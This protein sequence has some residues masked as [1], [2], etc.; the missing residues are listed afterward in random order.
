MK[1]LNRKLLAPIGAAVLG[2]LGVVLFRRRVSQGTPKEKLQKI[3]GPKAVHQVDID[4]YMG[5]WFEIARYPNPSEQRCY[6]SAIEYTRRP[7]G[8]IVV[9]N[10][11]RRGSFDAPL[12]ANEGIAHVVNDGTNTRLSM[13]SFWPFTG[14]Y[15][16]VDLDENYHYAVVSNDARTVLW[17]FSRSPEMPEEMYRRIVDRLADQGFDVKRIS[18]TP[19]PAREV[20]GVR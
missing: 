1:L 14:D 17:I 2:T 7:D 9:L 5:K 3:S 4:R 8:K 13:E 18:R 12:E 6:G 15:R 19:Q 20:A 11:C 10:Y 16:I